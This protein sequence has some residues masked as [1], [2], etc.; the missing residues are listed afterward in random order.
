MHEEDVNLVGGL[1]RPRES[2]EDEELK[3]GRDGEA[4]GA[5]GRLADAE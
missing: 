4:E 5:A 2:A 3:G 1:Q